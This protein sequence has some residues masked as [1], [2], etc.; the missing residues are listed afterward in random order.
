MR[1]INAAGYAMAAWVLLRDQDNDLHAQPNTEMQEAALRTARKEAAVAMCYQPAG[2]IDEARILLIAAQKL[3]EEADRL[4]ADL[5]GNDGDI[6]CDYE[7]ALHDA[8]A[9]LDEVTP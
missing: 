8:M 5:R 4:T 7:G 1:S 3:A 9:R 2:T 6:A